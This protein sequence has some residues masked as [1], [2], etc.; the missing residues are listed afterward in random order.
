MYIGIPIRFPISPPVFLI[1]ID[2]NS[3]SIN[4]VGFIVSE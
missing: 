3:S 2:R 1:A 4:N